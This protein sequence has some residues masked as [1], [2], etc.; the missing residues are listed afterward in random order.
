MGEAQQPL[1][2]M[3]TKARE[4]FSKALRDAHRWLDKLLFDP[5]QTIESLAVYEGKSDRSIRMTRNLGGSFIGAGS[6][7]DFLQGLLLL[8]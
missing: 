8:G 2:A 1:R 7:A 4:G 6:G 5:T 3:R